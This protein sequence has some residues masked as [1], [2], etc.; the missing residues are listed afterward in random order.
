MVAPFKQES[1]LA[2]LSDDVITTR[3]AHDRTLSVVAAN[4][5]L[6]L[7]ANDKE[8]FDLYFGFA[9]GFFVLELAVL[10]IFSS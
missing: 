8:S 5:N 10:K 3:L 6:E 2:A 4:P 9:L 1:D 7:D